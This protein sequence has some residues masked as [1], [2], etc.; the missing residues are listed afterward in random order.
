MNLGE[1]IIRSI[2]IHPAF[3]ESVKDF[4]I[5]QIWNETTNLNW[6]IVYDFI[7]VPIKSFVYM[8]IYYELG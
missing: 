1:N 5:G 3:K 8:A 6:S 2:S 7:Q 4:T